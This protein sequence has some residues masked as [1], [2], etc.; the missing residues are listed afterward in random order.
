MADDMSELPG[1]EPRL[2]GKE[3]ALM[4]IALIGL[5]LAATSMPQFAFG[6]DRGQFRDQAKEVVGKFRAAGEPK[7]RC[8]LGAN[9]YDGPVVGRASAEGALRPGDRLLMLDGRSVQGRSGDELI[10]LLR[11]ISPDARVAVTVDRGGELVDL[12][13]QCINARPDIE[14]LVN[15]LDLAAR[16]KFDDCVSEISTMRSMDARTAMIRAECASMSR[17]SEKHGVPALVAQAIELVIQD[18]H[19]VPSL[20]ADAVKALR[21]VEGQVVRGLGASK[22]DQLVAMTRRWP[23]G[24]S[25]FDQSGPDWRSFRRNAE[26]ALKSTLI[27]PDSARIQWTHGFMLGY[28][29]PFLSKKIEGYWTCGLINA[30]NRMG[31]YTGN[32]A[33]VVVLGPDGGVRYSEIGQ[34]GDYDLLSAS[35]AGSAK[36][37]PPPPSELLEAESS[38]GRESSSIADEIRKLVELRDAG[39]LSPEE[40]EAAKKRLL[41]R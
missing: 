26:T 28:W 35:C 4:R 12:E 30:R 8:S 1:V 32:T 24:E 14:P 40:F 11:A 31:G 37:L 15:A 7:D 38:P 3:I 25:L 5:V 10:S 23:G 29:K 16:G 39:A 36:R 21:Q 20:R 9:I 41:E 33:F 34:A 27:D 17:R 18:A 22:F 6:Q 2:E 19:Y 13:I